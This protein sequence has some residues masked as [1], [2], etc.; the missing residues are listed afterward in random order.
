[1]K[2][3]NWEKINN[4]FV[5]V[6]E[7]MFFEIQNAKTVSDE[8]YTAK[9][10]SDV[11]NLTIYV[12]LEN[13]ILIFS[14]G[15]NVKTWPVMLD[16]LNSFRTFIDFIG[17]CIGDYLQTFLDKKNGKVFSALFSDDVSL[18]DIFYQDVPASE[19]W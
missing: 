9:L 7:D 11:N 19:L 14:H 10:Y 2:I 1:M 4:I 15:R 17:T 18:P 6:T 13:G 5:D 16:D 3:E 8:I 12:K